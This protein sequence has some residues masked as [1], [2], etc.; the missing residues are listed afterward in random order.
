M[1]AASREDRAVVD[2]SFLMA[3]V[4]E[5]T[6]YLEARKGAGKMVLTMNAKWTEVL[7]GGWAWG[8]AD[9]RIIVLRR[10]CPRERRGSLSAP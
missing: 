7:A 2:K 10:I 1:L 3:Q 9:C 5:A 4:V 8:N 6:R